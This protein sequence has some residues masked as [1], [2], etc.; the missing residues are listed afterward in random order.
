MRRA[1]VILNTGSGSSDHDDVGPRVTAVLR[2]AGFDPRVI[3]VRAGEALHDAIH[4]A[5]AGDAELVVAGG[6]DGTISGIASALLDSGKTL[7]IVPLGTFNFFARRLNIPLDLEPA[8]EVLARGNSAVLDI[9][10]VNGQAFLNNASIGLYPAVLQQREAA[11]RKIGRSRAAAYLSTSKVLL[12]PAGILNLRLAADGMPIARRTPL[13]FVGAN[14][15]QMGAFAIPGQ[16]CI[17]SGRFAAYITRPLKP[18]ALVRLALR[19]VFR[20]LYGA[21]ELEVIC[22]R[23]LHVSLRPPQIRVAIDGEVRVLSTPLTFC[24]R[25]QA[26]R[27]ITGPPAAVGESDS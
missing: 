4:T 26:L 11:Y 22:A 23:E 18:I 25:P 7:G 9:A 14:A 12:Q 1:D 19:A 3:S 20:G 16:D 24:W 2:N 21:R 27:V 17:E 6:G 5:A 13:L 10:E 15:T 8:L